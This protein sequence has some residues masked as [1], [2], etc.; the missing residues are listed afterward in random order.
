ML[1]LPRMC[2]RVVCVCVC[3]CVCVYARMHVCVCVY[4]CMCVCVC[5]YARM[6]VCVCVCLCV[7]V[8]ARMRVCVCVYAC[9]RA[10]VYSLHAQQLQTLTGPT[11]SATCE[12][13]VP[14]AAPRYSTRTKWRSGYTRLP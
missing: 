12:T 14:D 1:T 5:V 4:A 8:Y 7:R 13:V 6:R 3:V 10:C 2:M 9:V 11:M